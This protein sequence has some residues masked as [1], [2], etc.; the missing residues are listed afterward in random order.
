M[1]ERMCRSGYR[2][3][4]RQPLVL[5]GSRA[6]VVSLSN[7]EQDGSSFDR[8]RMSG[9][10]RHV[11]RA[12]PVLALALFLGAPDDERSLEQRT[13]DDDP[14]DDEDDVREIVEERH[15]RAFFGGF[16]FGFAVAFGLVLDL[17]LTV[18]CQASVIASPSVSPSAVANCTI[19]QP[20]RPQAPAAGTKVSGSARTNSVC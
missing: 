5:Q 6:L 10:S 20:L 15:Q 18:P 2:R 19:V 14:D 4:R 9:A 17:T 16:G 7:H 3:L 8:L 1:N 12:G 11:F 13:H